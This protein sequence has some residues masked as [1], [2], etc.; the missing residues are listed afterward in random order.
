MQPFPVDYISVGRGINPCEDTKPR[1]PW[2]KALECENSC[3]TVS[4]I[5]TCDAS[6][7][8]DI[9]FQI[10]LV[11]R[12]ERWKIDSC[13]GR[14]NDIMIYISLNFSLNQ[15]E[16][17]HGV[18][19]DS[20]NGFRDVFMFCHRSSESDST[21]SCNRASLSCVCLCSWGFILVWM[22]MYFWPTAATAALL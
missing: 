21:L 2:L 16:G 3:E 14:Q 19:D 15:N 13:D 22:F 9:A 8:L 20:I 11:W 12:L 17:V 6:G 4:Q 10:C 18:Q 7:P 1:Q 5:Q